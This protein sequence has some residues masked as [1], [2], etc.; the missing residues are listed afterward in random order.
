[1][2][3]PKDLVSSENTA[4]PSFAP[5]AA[6]IPHI[7]SPSLMIR[8]DHPQHPSP[9]EEEKIYSS[10]ARLRKSFVHKLCSATKSHHQFCSLSSHPS[11]CLTRDNTGAVPATQKRQRLP[12]LSYQTC[13]LLPTW[14]Q[15]FPKHLPQSR[16]QYFRRFK[17]NILVQQRQVTST[18]WHSF[19]I[20]LFP[21]LGHTI[22][23][24]PDRSTTSLQH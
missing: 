7:P 10:P 24:S 5:A 2:G 13:S 17:Q 8:G 20:S 22:K 1:M 6:E 12:Q 21:L 19:A 18:I 23:P 15:N 3:K 11:I 4:S 9:E 16:E 14:T